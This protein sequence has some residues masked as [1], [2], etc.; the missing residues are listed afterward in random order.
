MRVSFA[1]EA[2]V[3]RLLVIVVAAL[4]F[5]GAA[6]AKEFK[7][8][9]LCGASGCATSSAPEDVGPLGVAFEDNRL[10]EVAPP[11]VQ[12]YY[13]VEIN[14]GGTDSWTQWYVPGAHVFSTFD[15][16]ALPVWWDSQALAVFRKLALRVKPFS[17]PTLSKAVVDGKRVSDPNA[18]LPLIGGL[19][20]TMQASANGKWIQ[21]VLTPSRPS[22][23]LQD[24][25]PIMFSPDASVL[26][27]YQ[28]RRVPL[29]LANVIRADAGLPTLSTG[30][31][32]LGPIEW[33][34]L[35]GWIPIVIALGLFWTRRRGRPSAAPA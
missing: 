35:V 6:A 10:L 16:N 28:P 18:Y 13:R 22:P 23:W 30:D 32:G 24:T 31:G 26:E 21:L 2:I 11:A 3:K 19:P 34:V 25:T 15:E 4:V 12:A 27:L 7:A 33:G 14:V 9:T 20:G 1:K 17:A 29:A 5:P 8:V